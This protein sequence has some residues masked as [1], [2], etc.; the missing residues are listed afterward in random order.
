M[1]RTAVPMSDFLPSFYSVLLVAVGYL[2]A[3]EGVAFL[4]PLDPKLFVTF[5]VASVLSSILSLP[6]TRSVTYSIFRFFRSQLFP[7]R[8]GSVGR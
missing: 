6:W 1:Q 5:P 7:V 8:S 3:C 4:F 2:C